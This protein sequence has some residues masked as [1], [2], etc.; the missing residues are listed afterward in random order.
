MKKVLILGATSAIAQHVARLLA[1]RG[2]SLYLVAR[3]PNQLEAVRQDV[4][5]RGAAK[6][7]AFT[8]DLN[9]FGQH[10]AL[11][12]RA[13]TA[14]G[15]LDMVLLAHGVLG[16]QAEC[17]KSYAAAEKVFTTNFNSFVS[18]LTVV[19][20][21]FEAQ[22]SGTIVA[23]SSVAG[24]RGRQSNYVYGSAKAALTAYLQGLRNR[25]FRSGVKVVTV[26]PGLVDTPMT[27]H[28]KKGPL[29]TTPDVVAK[30]IV[31]AAQKGKDEVYL[32]GRWWLIMFIIRAIPE[33]VFKRLKL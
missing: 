31:R 7:E 28:L 21:R 30:G 4:A 5:T 19:A 22:R 10:E 24:D 16:D 1:A 2:A 15:G 9:D 13:F 32:P 26:K 14:L 17:E 12:E 8:V 3:N 33:F 25:L 11:V 23:I 18:L 29:F 27:A 6:A 20:N